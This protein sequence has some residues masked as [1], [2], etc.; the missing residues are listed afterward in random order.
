MESITARIALTDELIAIRRHLHAHPERSFH[1]T[2]TSAYLERVLRDRGIDVL[3]NPMETGVVAQITGAHAGPTVALRADID[4]LP[5]H[6]D[7]GLDF[8]SVTP[9]VMHGCGHD[10]HM[11]SLLG[12]VFW[13]SAHRELIGGTVRIIFQPAEE[14]G[15]GARAVIDA[16]LI[17][18]V[19]AIIGTHNNPNYAPGTLAAGTAPMMAGCVRF[20]VTLHAQ[21]THAGYPHKGTGPLEAMASMIMSLQ[22]IVSRNVTPFHP[23]VVSVTEV[24]GGDVWNVVPAEAGFQGTVRYFHREDGDLAAERFRTIVEQTAAAYGIAASVDWDDFQDPLV[25]DPALIEP[26]CAHIPQYAS[27]APIMPSMAGEDFVEYAKVTR[28]VFAFVGSNGT[29]GCAD[30]HSPRFVGFDETVRTGA[31]FYA[32]AALD[33]L[34]ALRVSGAR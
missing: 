12:A 19:K 13:L 6:E 2:E 33:V 32:N 10:L 14:L 8:A 18:G 11:A 24:H 9:G 27:L 3:A 1:E 28:P 22:T 4:G 34:D 29:P 16:G 5:I 30:W 21:G 15:L 25:S 17:D 23:L 26:V 31:D 20:G 7:S